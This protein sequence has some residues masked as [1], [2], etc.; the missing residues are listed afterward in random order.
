VWNQFGEN[1][2]KLLDAMIILLTYII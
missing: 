1:K 2:K